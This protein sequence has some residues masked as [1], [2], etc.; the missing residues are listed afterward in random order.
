VVGPVPR[1]HQ[2]ATNKAAVNG[3][4]ETH[5]NAA[6]RPAVS[7][8]PADPGGVALTRGLASP[9]PLATRTARFGFGI[10]QVFAIFGEGDGRAQGFA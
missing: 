5:N 3:S 4:T 2:S 10:G 7:R 6:P 1:S 9:C 8:T